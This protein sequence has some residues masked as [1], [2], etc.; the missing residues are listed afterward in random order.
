MSDERWLFENVH[1]GQVLID[2]QS[3]GYTDVQ[4]PS[5]RSEWVLIAFPEGEHPAFIVMTVD[6]SKVRWDYVRMFVDQWQAGHRDGWSPLPEGG[7][8]ITCTDNALPTWEP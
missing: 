7:Y 6:E 5:L 2:G 3:D 8:A 4:V 1:G